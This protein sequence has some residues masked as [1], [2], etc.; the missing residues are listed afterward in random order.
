VQSQHDALRALPPD[1]ADE[2]LQRLLDRHALDDAPQQIERFA[3]C[4]TH[5]YINGKFLE[6]RVVKALAAPLASFQC[7]QDLAIN[8]APY[9]MPGDVAPAL[10]RLAG[11]LRALSL[12]G[13]GAE[14]IEQAGTSTGFLSSSTGLEALDLS[15]YRIPYDAPP[16]GFGLTGVAALTRLTSL[17]LAGLPV[18]D[19]AARGFERLRQLRHLD[20]SRSQLTP[21]LL[22]GVLGSLT[23]LTSLVLAEHEAGVLPLFANLRRLDLGRCRLASVVPFG[24]SCDVMRLEELKASHAHF[25]GPAA[26]ALPQVLRASAPHLRKLTLHG[27][28]LPLGESVLQLLPELAGATQL[29]FLDLSVPSRDDSDDDEGGEDDAIEPPL[30]LA[31]LGCT[32][33]KEL[34][35]IGSLMR[36]PVLGSFLRGVTSL[37]RV[38]VHNG[39]FNDGHVRALAAC[40]LPLL[41]ELAV[42][43]E[44]DTSSD[45]NP[46]RQLQ[47][48][49]SVCIT[50]TQRAF[51]LLG[52]AL[53]GALTSLL[54]DG[55]I[56]PAALKALCSR[57]TALQKLSIYNWRWSARDLEDALAPLPSLERVDVVGCSEEI[58]RDAA[59]LARLVARLPPCAITVLARGGLYKISEPH[60]MAC[61]VEAAA[62]ATAEAEAAAA[63]TA[64]A[65]AEGEEGAEAAEG[66]Q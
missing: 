12:S 23:R 36:A 33:L 5:V 43:L 10:A 34:A 50:A 62:A 22:E 51:D 45:S 40:P 25:D 2:L 55:D 42:S 47:G 44:G 30:P 8:N 4:A 11:T 60:E 9:L 15:S 14:V 54:I 18:T 1:L 56:K 20:L 49:R 13:C 38:R 57:C 66:E 53:G 58:R 32:Q 37:R 48:L 21:G 28:T 35:L 24:R 6:C 39:E 41:E 59:G 29:S 7:L 52:D 31:A 61:F 26:V 17:K 16:A 27:C 65:A 46:W 63:A 3:A 64:A 19:D